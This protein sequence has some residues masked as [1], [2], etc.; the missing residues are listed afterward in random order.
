M[1]KNRKLKFNFRGFHC[2]PAV[3]SDPYSK[4]KYTTAGFASASSASFVREMVRLP[5]P[6]FFLFEKNPAILVVHVRLLH[7]PREKCC[8]NSGVRAD[9][10]RHASVR[11]Q[12][13]CLD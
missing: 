11:S 10:I 12:H 8:N 13:Q 7:C 4:N 3:S 2:R 1:V 9:C 6:I 5:T